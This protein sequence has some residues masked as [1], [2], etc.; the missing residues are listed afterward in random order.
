MG[1]ESGV[2]AWE[3]ELSVTL[4]EKQQGPRATALQFLHFF[5][6][7]FFTL[8]DNMVIKTS[9]FYFLNLDMSGVS[10]HVIN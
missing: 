9:Y 5:V 6:V 3:E 1:G 4:E 7:F 10:L 2:G 8:C